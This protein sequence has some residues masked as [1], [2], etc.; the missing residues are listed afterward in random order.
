MIRVDIFVCPLEFEQY[1]NIPPRRLVVLRTLPAAFDDGV[2]SVPRAVV[3]VIL[4][5][6]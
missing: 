1:N 3:D 5:D 2:V 6:N 4:T